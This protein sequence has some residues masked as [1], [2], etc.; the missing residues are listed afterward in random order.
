MSVGDVIA[1]VT[2][3]I[4][5][6]TDLYNRIDSVKQAADDL[7]LL[8]VH[9][10]VLSKVFKG[11]ENDIIMAY[12][13]EFMRMLGILK[14]IQESYNKCA[15]VLG[16]E[17]AGTTTATQKTAI[18]GKSFAKRVVIFTRIP[19]ILA[20]I[21]Y[22]AEQLQ[23]IS[24]ILSVSFL[25]DVRKH[26][27]KSS[28]K[29]PLNSPTAKNTTLHDN[30]LNLDLSTGFASIDRMVE[31]LMNECKHLEH[32]LQETTLF[33]DTSAVQIYQAQN[34]EG[35]S[36]WKDRFQKG[37][38][39][40]SALR[41]ETFYVSWARFVHE[42]E[43][44][45][46]LKMIP[47]GIFESENLD[48][49]RLQGSRYSINQSGTRRLSTIRPLWLPALR[50]ALDPLHKGYVKPDDYFKL[51]HDCSLSDTLRRLVLESAGYGTFVECERASGDLALPAAIESPSGHIG[52]IS[53]QIVAVPT[54]DELGIVTVQEVTESSSDAIFAHFNGTAGDVHVY[55][56]Y[57]ETGQIERKSLSKQVR[58]VG[59]ISV[60]AAL[61]IRHELDSGEHAW[62]CD[63][64]IT[65]FKAFQGGEP[66][67]ASSDIMLYGNDN[68]ASFTIPEFDC[69]LL[70]PSKVFINPP[71]VGEKVQIEY[72]GFWYDSRVT[73]VDGDEIEFV[74]WENLPKKGETN[75]TQ[76]RHLGEADEKEDGNLF[77][78]EE[79]LIQLGKGTRR[80]WRPWRR[81][82]NRYDVRPYRCFHIGDTTEAP[83]M[84]P[85][86]RFH[87]HVTDN[88]Q[89]YLPA[90]IVD[91][92]GDQYVIEFSPAFSV[93][94]WWPGRMPQGEQ[95]D[96]VP[97]SDIKMENP[98][99]FNRVTVAMDRVR[100]F[101]AGPRP[102][103][104][105]QSAMPSGWS[106]FQGIHLC[107]LEDLLEGSLWNNDLDNER[108]GG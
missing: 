54:P 31:N 8:T 100:P 96:L 76:A 38:L 44:S 92:Q 79:Q 13:S 90:R 22:K 58:P 64:R 5:V 29:E 93:H 60:G 101:I 26:Q 72:D 18:N 6:G 12:S 86:F 56:R 15:K 63:L 3:L 42:V 106:S 7:L 81:N 57:L 94:S 4:N 52:W 67:K 73:A 69:T 66:L 21:R 49:V 102:V 78:P 30:L 103:L 77:F 37:K 68:S 11:S 74:D 104:G 25:S 1:V 62:S 39:Y 46:V 84:Y 65:E 107:D 16:V 75:I 108:V 91:V 70:G 71:K 82:T 80:L 89:L 19:S 98:F 20:E 28:R 83:V 85:D 97:G 34:P 61:S 87:Y 47:T 48:R 23:K 36:F 53:A 105:V 95:I 27:K 99:D 88:S 43:T 55:V 45:F 14:S 59:G 40:A 17:S 35:A 33:P 50:S 9:L 10:Q 24:S 51:I 2:I 41:Y 32:Q